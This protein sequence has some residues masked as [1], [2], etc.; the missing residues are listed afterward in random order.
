MLMEFHDILP[1]PPMAQ[2]CPNFMQFLGKLKKVVYWHPLQKGWRPLLQKSWIHPCHSL[3]KC[4]LVQRN[5]TYLNSQCRYLE[6]VYPFW[7]R[8]HFKMRYLYITLVSCWIFGI[9][10]NAAYMIPTGKVCTF[11]KLE[12]LQF[13][14][15]CLQDFCLQDKIPK[16]FCPKD[17]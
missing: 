9:G 11:N 6:L 15:L 13:Y 12:L 3:R 16:K 1:P 17:F 10:F 14:D 2:H 7:H 5:L 8:T 4:F